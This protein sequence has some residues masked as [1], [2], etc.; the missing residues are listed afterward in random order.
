MAIQ[1]GYNFLLVRLSHSS[2]ATGSIVMIPPVQDQFFANMVRLNAGCMHH[3]HL[4][5]IFLLDWLIIPWFWTSNWIL[6][7]MDFKQ[8]HIYVYDSQQKWGG[9]TR[10]KAATGL[11]V[12][13]QGETVHCAVY[14]IW[15]AKQLILGNTDL[16]SWSFSIANSQVERVVIAN[17]LSVTIHADTQEH[18]VRQLESRGIML[19]DAEV[20]QRISVEVSNSPAKGS[21]LL[22]FDKRTG[23][24]WP[25]F[26]LEI[27]KSHTIIDWFT[28]IYDKRPEYFP[29]GYT[30]D[31]LPGSDGSMTIAGWT[32]YMNITYSWD[33]LAHIEWPAQLRKAPMFFPS[34][35][36][37]HQQALV[38]TLQPLVSI[39]TGNPK[40][41]PPQ[42]SS[43]PEQFYRQP[44]G[45][46]PGQEPFC[47]AEEAYFTSLGS[48]IRQMVPMPPKGSQQ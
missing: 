15:F 41:E 5:N 1:P 30:L 24:A 23:K 17:Q 6:V 9:K 48:Q 13:Q 2:S 14:T 44:L 3:A 7:V 34:P 25:A 37:P 10:A 8:C 22:I 42:I 47:A 38:D 39:I 45:A 43:T 18:N 40:I 20:H 11:G 28:G 29:P 36:H 4:Y 26:I 27:T 32:D 31:R 19:D 16:A 33:Q 35:L 21:C 12:P 46:A